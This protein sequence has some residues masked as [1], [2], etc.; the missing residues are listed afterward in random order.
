MEIKEKEII[1]SENKY[2]HRK[3][4]DIY[5]KRCILL[6]GETLENFEEVDNIPDEELEII[7]KAKIDELNAY[8][9]NEGNNGVN[10]FF[11]NDISLWLT[12]DLRGNIGRQI[13]ANILLSNKTTDLPINGAVVSIPNDTA[14]TMLAKLELYAG[15]CYNIRERKEKEI[16]ALKTKEDINNYDIKSEY[17]EKLKFT[18]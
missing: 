17:P 1:A 12:P 9:N 7:R 14:K 8:Y 4:S 3:S 18:L 5:F 13:E 15:Q 16:N 10:E 2:I 6:N 11:V